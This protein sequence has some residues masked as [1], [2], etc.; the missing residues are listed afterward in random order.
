MTLDQYG[1]TSLDHMTHIN[2]LETIFKYGLQA[3]SNSYKKRDI[4]NKEVNNRRESRENIYGRKIHE[5]VP[6]YFNPRNAMMYK[7]RYED[8]VIL[9]F[10][11][12]LLAQDGILFTD[13]NAST[14]SVHFYNKPD[15]LDKINWNL[16]KSDRWNDKASIVKQIM[17]AEVLVYKQV[18]ISF[19]KGIYVKNE[20]T[21]AMLMKKYNLPS[22]KIAI[23]S[24]LFF[25]Y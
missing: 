14:N 15:D 10:D 23:K 11:K 12:K 21:K 5:Y 22:R 1:F 25:Q 13:R 17:M 6:F 2:N 3:H 9:A 24:N 18:P 19:L 20:T 7:N 8:V 16:V 4:S